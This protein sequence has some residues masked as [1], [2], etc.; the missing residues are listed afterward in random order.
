MP[1]LALLALLTLLAAPALAARVVVIVS[2]D[3]GP[4]TEPVQPFLDALDEPADVYNLRGREADA[5][6]L[7]ARLKNKPPEVIFALGAKAAWIARERL[8]DIPLVF[9]SIMA[10]RRF[11]I[12]GKGT[13]GIAMVTAPELA[14]SQFNG[15]FS[16]F[17]RIGV[18]R[19]PSIPDSRIASMEKAAELIGVTLTVER[20]RSPR[21]VRQ[22]MHRLASKVQV[23]WL[24]NDREVLD[25]PTFRFIVEES[26]RTRMP[27]VVETENM[28]RAGALF[29][30]V[31]DTAGV[32]RQA[33]GLVREV[34]DDD[35]VLR[36]ELLDPQDIDIV[37]N[38][39]V[40]RTTG[41]AFEPM[42]LDF[43]D[44]VVE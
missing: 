11:D 10:P 26:Q 14:V 31:P 6:A 16:N 4:Y 17:E 44:V 35:R 43:I 34:L 25:R 7:A 23:I 30:T 8:P 3:L 15:F 27:L 22:A 33:A 36:G 21:D 39:A 1:R 41:T 5:Q 9:A 24:Q 20:V 40:L 37:L 42:M 12:E 29:A 28:V 19:G 18:L 32:G 13:A 2:D 38:R